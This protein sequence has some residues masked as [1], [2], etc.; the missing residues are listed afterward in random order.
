MNYISATDWQMA[1]DNV[2]SIN[3]INVDPLLLFELS[4][5]GRL[6][7]VPDLIYF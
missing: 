5:R 6:D 7:L 2:I 3:S 1:A 4:G